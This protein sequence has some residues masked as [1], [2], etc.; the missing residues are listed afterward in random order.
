MPC[1][2]ADK[3][4]TNFLV[5]PV[6]SIFKALPWRWRQHFPTLKM[7]VAGSFETLVP[8]YQTTQQAG[9]AMDNEVGG[10]C[11]TYNGEDKYTRDGGGETWG[12][13]TTWKT[14]A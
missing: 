8:T 5:E 4:I 6:A 10:A 7:E 12:R 2:L 13:E 9:V 1:S 11:V 3:Y 14:Q